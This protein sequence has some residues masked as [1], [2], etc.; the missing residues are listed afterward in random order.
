MRMKK[1]SWKPYVCL[2]A[3]TEAV[4]GLSGWLTRKGVKAYHGVAKSRLT[5]PDM[6][7]PIVWAALFALMGAGAARVWQAPPSPARTRGL[8]LFALQLAVNFAWS[9]LF[10]NLQAFGFAFFWLILLWVLILLMTLSFGKV[11]RIS[12]WMQVPYLLWVAF[13]GYLNCTTWLLNR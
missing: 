5:P 7:F 1:H 12:A 4:G 9:L 2:I 10:F 8:T 6:V 13:A 3:L 11:D